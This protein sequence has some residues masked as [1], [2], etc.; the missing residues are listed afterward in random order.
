M[1]VL[2]ATGASGGH[3]FPALELAQC[4]RDYN[5]EVILAGSFG[6]MK[7][8]ITDKGFY[9]HEVGAIGLSTNN[10]MSMLKASFFM[11]RSFFKS[12]TILREAQPDVVIGFGSFGAFPLVLMASLFQVPTMIHEQNVVPGRANACL[13]KFVKKIAISFQESERY[14]P[15]PKTV[16]TGCPCRKREGIGNKSKIMEQFQLQEGNFTLLVLGGSQGSQRLNAVVMDA[17]GF[18]KDSF[19]LQVIHITGK[20]DAA[21]VKQEYKNQGITH[22]VCPFLKNID[23]VYGI[24]D[25]IVARAGAMTVTEIAYH[26]LP[27]ILIPYPYARGHQKENASLLERRK[28]AVVIEEQDLSAQLL[29]EKIMDI[30]NNPIPKERLQETRALLYKPDAAERMVAELRGLIHA[31]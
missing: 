4:L 23:E 19:P 24:A 11:I 14:F 7:E 28:T 10:F 13:K 22:H 5:D 6:R 29:K 27:A 2:I 16:L 25:V 17:I 12:I 1:R 9:H 30:N 3:I 31:E 21:K 26:V 20:K 15:P 8:W 18:L